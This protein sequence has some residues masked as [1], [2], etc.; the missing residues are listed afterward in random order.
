MRRRSSF[1]K[2]RWQCSGCFWDLLLFSF[3]RSKSHW[4]NLLHH[5]EKV[6]GIKVVQEAYLVP[7]GDSE[8]QAGV[9]IPGIRARLHMQTN[10][11][12]FRLELKPSNFDE[13]SARQDH[14]P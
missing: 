5:L 8:H 7:Y 4:N 11:R 12:L 13:E 3:F 14:A 6:K 2:A 9:S 10:N 1:S